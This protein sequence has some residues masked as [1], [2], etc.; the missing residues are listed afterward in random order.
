MEVIDEMPRKVP[1]PIVSSSV[2][3]YSGLRF[4]SISESWSWSSGTGRTY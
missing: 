3:S 1:V 4:C 2:S